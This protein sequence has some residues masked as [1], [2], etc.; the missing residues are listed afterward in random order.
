VQND[1]YW[2]QQ[3]AEA[4]VGQEDVEIPR[5]LAWY[6]HDVK[7]VGQ[8]TGDKAVM[9]HAQL[10]DL[11]EKIYA[12][13][14]SLNSVLG[15]LELRTKTFPGHSRETSGDF[16]GLNYVVLDYLSTIASC[17]YERG[18][19]PTVSYS[20]DNKPAI[21]TSIEDVRR[22]AHVLTIAEYWKSRSCV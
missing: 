22:K 11:D 5:K 1:R 20:V 9:L 10:P 15:A 8:Q 4:I 13:T 16:K 7:K 6:V 3:L 21:S 18:L 19:E 12:C 17:L 14:F 2:I